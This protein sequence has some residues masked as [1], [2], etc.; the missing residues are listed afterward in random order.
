MKVDKEI[1]MDTL[2]SI[3]R[4]LSFQDIV[5]YWTNKTKDD[6]CYNC[7]YIFVNGLCPCKIEHINNEVKKMRD[8]NE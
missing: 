6:M 1:Y 3:H 5:E 4:E 8:K 2:L 7:S